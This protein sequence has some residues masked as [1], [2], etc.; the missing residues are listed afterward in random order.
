MSRK[1]GR[2]AVP[3]PVMLTELALAS[4][5]TIARR[6]L[7]IAE[8]RCSPAEWQRMV[9]EKARAAE[10]SLVAFA[11]PLSEE[12]LTAAVAPWHRGAVANAK[13]LRRKTPRT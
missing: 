1:P 5:E 11:A 7:M 13:R 3:L 2:S 4:W 6:S 8:G 10:Q 12:T 9:M